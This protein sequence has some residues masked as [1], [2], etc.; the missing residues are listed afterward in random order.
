MSVLIFIEISEGEI[1]KSSFEAAVYGSQVAQKTGET[2]YAIALGDASESQLAQLGA[3]GV[4]EVL[5][6]AGSHLAEVNATAFAKIVT[7]AV[8]K[9][10][11]NLIVAAK[12]S[13][14]DAVLSRLA[15]AL[16]AG[17]VGNVT[18]LPTFEDGFR[19]KRSIFT[20]KA[21]AEVKVDTPIKVLTIKKNAVEA[22]AGEGLAQVTSFTTSVNASD[23]VG[24]V[25]ETIKASG[26]ISLPE[27]DIVVSGGRGMKGPEH[28]AP[29]QELADALGAATACSKP[30]SDADWRPHHE[31][32]GQTGVK[33][34]PNLYIACGISGA[35][36]HLAGV[37]SSKVIVVINK[38]PEAPFF[39]AADYGIIGDVFDVLP[40]L[41]AAVKSL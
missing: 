27:A 16:K 34:A 26:T 32:V 30:V 29:L 12:S 38:D 9:V 6:V 39:K 41:T 36:Q 40:K 10:Q 28:W 20:G 2:S 7:E 19:V 22:I 13:V 8:Q 1:K 35:I 14:S 24:K 11:A 33:V 4:Q 31:H 15:G 18:E 21:F 23:F 37:N 25:T 5:H 3:Y 17:I